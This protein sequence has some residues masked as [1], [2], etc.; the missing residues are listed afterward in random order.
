MKA[1]GLAGVSLVRWWLSTLETKIVYYDPAVDPASPLCRGQYIYVF[2]HE[3]LL[4]PL[5]FRGGS[6]IAILVSQHRDADILSYAA[7][8]LRVRLVRGST[9]RGGAAAVRQLL[10]QGGRLHLTI[11]P[12]GPRGPRRRLAPGAVY[13]ASRLGLPLVLVGMGYDRPWR[14]GS[15]DRFAVPRPYCRARVVAGPAV[16]VPP[17]LDRK[18]LEEFREKVERLLNRLTEEAEAWAASGRRMEGQQTLRR[19]VVPNGK[20]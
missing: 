3:Y 15:W 1:G 6:D 10:R 19:D 20:R 9:R 17:E 12:D 4:L 14:L 7:R 11:T 2:W 5:A 8:H 16:H 18:S 13:L